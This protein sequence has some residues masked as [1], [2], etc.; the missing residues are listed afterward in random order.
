MTKN[1]KKTPCPYFSQKQGGACMVIKGGLYLPLHEHI[2]TYCN[3][4]EFSTCNQYNN[5]ALNRGAQHEVDAD[6]ATRRRF[7]RVKNTMPV[8]I[9][10]CDEK[11]TPVAALDDSAVTLDIG[12]G[13]MKI[14]SRRE[15]RPNM[16][17]AFRF[18]DDYIPSTLTGVGEVR[19]TRHLPD[20]SSFQAG[21]SFTDSAVPNALGSRF[22]LS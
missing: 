12:M 19:W 21:I 18:A 15:I 8:A 13:G 4:A 7:R 3:T 11:G 2:V 9:Y 14:S 1:S 22:A 16:M 17:L 20:S 10:T 5:P 6:P